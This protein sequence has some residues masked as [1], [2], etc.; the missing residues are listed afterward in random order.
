[1]LLLWAVGCATPQPPETTSEPEV[2]RSQP[3]G[4]PASNLVAQHRNGRR[5]DGRKPLEISELTTIPVDGFDALDSEQQRIALAFYNATTAP[6]E[7]CMDAGMSLGTCIEG[8]AEGCDN[9][10]SVARRVVRLVAD[11]RDIDSISEHV[12]FADA[13]VPGLPRAGGDTAISL[14]GVYDDGGLSTGARATW[15]E[16]AAACEGHV[17]LIEVN[18]AN[19]HPDWGVRSAPTQF[20]NGYRLRGAQGAEQMQRIVRAELE[21][22]GQSCRD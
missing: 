2:I 20:V 16:V 7:P 4:E 18:I 3:L 1:M 6:C 13:W 21:D 19:A 8:G 10:A 12:E 22:L 9:L 15:G 5:P 14:V 17:E 11:G